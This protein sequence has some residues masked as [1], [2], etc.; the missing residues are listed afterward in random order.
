MLI[1]PEDG[2]NRY[3]PAYAPDGS[4][5]LY[6]ESDCPAG[7]TY[8]R[9]CDADADPTAALWALRGDG[10]RIPLTNINAP[11]PADANA[12]LAQTYPKWA[13]FV[14]PQRTDGSGRLMWFTFSSMRRYGL[15][16]PSSNSRGEPGQ[17]IWMAAVDPDAI[18]RGE[19]GSFA[20]FA[21]PFQDLRTSNHIAQWTARVVPTE[22]DPNP[23]DPCAQ[24][25]E[26]CAPGTDPCCS[27]ATC[28]DNRNNVFICRPDF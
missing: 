28:T 11:G 13:P 18:A 21:L 7:E 1:A 26:S 25:G 3:Y 17:L 10:E 2:K 24:V 16:P 22:P 9:D 4:F 27:G 19:D 23:K 20:P 6:N 5:L 14:D 15:H 12:R 8:H